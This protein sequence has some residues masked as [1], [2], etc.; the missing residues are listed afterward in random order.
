MTTSVE[1]RTWHWHRNTPCRRSRDVLESCQE[2]EASGNDPASPKGLEYR[3]PRARSARYRAPPPC[4]QSRYLPARSSR[5]TRQLFVDVL[6]P[7]F[8]RKRWPNPH[9]HPDDP[10]VERLA[11]CLVH[12]LYRLGLASLPD[13]RG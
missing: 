3:Q 7:M 10:P 13:R 12:L 6:P 5:S 1:S 4:D 8:W 11:Y 2:E 9:T